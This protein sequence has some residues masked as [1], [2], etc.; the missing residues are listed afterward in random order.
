MCEKNINFTGKIF[1][2]TLPNFR[3]IFRRCSSTCI[4]LPTYQGTG[5]L[6]SVR[7]EP[8]GLS[9]GRLCFRDP[10]GVVIEGGEM[11]KGAGIRM[12]GV[13]SAI[14]IIAKVCVAQNNTLWLINYLQ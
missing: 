1:I 4:Y 13:G 9:E 3:E 6:R 5:S 14:T 2:I 7:L 10:T 8:Q 11:V 12:D